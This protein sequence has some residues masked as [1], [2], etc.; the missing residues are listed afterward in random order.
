M[1]LQARITW[2]RVGHA[3]L[4][5]HFLRQELADRHPQA[6]EDGKRRFGRCNR[7]KRLHP[8]EDKSPVQIGYSDM[9]TRSFGCRRLVFVSRGDYCCRR[10]RRHLHHMLALFGIT[11][12]LLS[13]SCA[14]PPTYCIVDAQEWPL[15]P[16]FRLNSTT[17]ST[18]C[19]V[20]P[21][22]MFCSQG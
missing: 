2:R 6:G 18:S 13:S 1:H 12:G 15:L 21:T 14:L 22:S 7:P 20:C 16:V 11:S 10:Y 9:K 8:R 4:S 17:T 3:F 5:S 19:A